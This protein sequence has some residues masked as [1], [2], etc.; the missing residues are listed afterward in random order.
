MVLES[1]AI[2]QSWKSGITT[3]TRGTPLSRVLPAWA[4]ALPI[5]LHDL[6]G[7]TF[8]PYSLFFE[9]KCLALLLWGHKAME[10]RVWWLERGLPTS[11]LT[12]LPP[13]GLSTLSLYKGKMKPQG[14]GKRVLEL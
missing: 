7:F 8:S 13:P 14:S 10:A 5:S 2:Y 9:K 12:Q 4:W 1:D 3:R 11:P 6:R